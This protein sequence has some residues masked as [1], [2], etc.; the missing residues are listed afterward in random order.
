MTSIVRII[1][2]REDKKDEEIKIYNTVN[3]Y[4]RDTDT[5]KIV[6]TPTAKDTYTFHMTSS[7]IDS[8]IRTLLSSMMIDQDPYDHIQVTTA[9]YPS[10][11][12]DGTDLKNYAIHNSIID[13]VNSTLKFC[14][15]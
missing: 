9:A 12:Y 15:E 1:F 4:G 5:F 3:W 8:Y 10:I 14:P 11:L 2:M 6:F 7:G 13:L